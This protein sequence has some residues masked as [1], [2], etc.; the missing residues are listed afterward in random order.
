MGTQTTTTKVHPLLAKIGGA[1]AGD[2]S[3]LATRVVVAAVLLVACSLLSLQCNPSVGTRYVP[4][5]VLE[6]EAV[7]LPSEEETGPMSRVLLAVGDS[8]QTHILLPPPVPLPG[9][10]IPLE[11]EEFRKGN[12]EYSLDLKKWLAEGP[13]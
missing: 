4:G 13:S 7:G 10:F 5:L 12:V 9:H 1:L 11:A 2:R 3:S 6:I 8:S